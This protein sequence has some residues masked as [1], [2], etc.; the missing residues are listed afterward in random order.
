MGEQIVARKIQTST[1]NSYIPGHCACGPCVAGN[2]VPDC[3]LTGGVNDW[4][5]WWNTCCGG[6][7]P[8]QR[9]CVPIDRSECSIGLDSQGRDP[10]VS[11]TWDGSAPNLKC[12][13][14][15][16]NVDKKEQLMAFERIFGKSDAITGAYCGQPVPT[17]AEGLTSCSRYKSVGEGG[18]LCRE[19]YANLKSDYLRDAVAQNYCFRHDTDDCK[20][21]NRTLTEEYKNL[22][23]GNPINDKCWFVPCANP[24]RY[25]VPSDLTNGTCPEN[26]CEIIFNIYKDRDVTIYDNDIVCNFNPTPAGQDFINFIKHYWGI[27]VLIVLLALLFAV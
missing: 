23:R 24:S 22:K 15:I 19:W 2:P 14:D 6:F 5:E 17:C 20:C 21:V 27:P 16:G 26:V 12:V 8:K 1:A 11:I 13:Y 10:L 25:F 7:C 18:D 4:T 3:N 9:S